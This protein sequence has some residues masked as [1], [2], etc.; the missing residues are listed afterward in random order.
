MSSE[1]PGS[2]AVA[3]IDCGGEIVG[4]ATEPESTAV[5]G[6]GGGGTGGAR[7]GLRQG[8]LW[9]RHRRTHALWKQGC[10]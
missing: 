3:F 9:L 7:P 10:A 8:H 2:W 1:D 6:D 5:P 4:G